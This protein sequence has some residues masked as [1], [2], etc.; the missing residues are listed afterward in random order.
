MIMNRFIYAIITVTLL[1]STV[2]AASEAIKVKFPNGSQ[3]RISNSGNLQWKYVI[4]G[5]TWIL[6]KENG[7]RI[8]FAKEKQILATGV[9]IG[10]KLKMET[11]AGALF[12]RVKTAE[13]KIKFTCGI[14]PRDYEF[15]RTPEKIKVR[16]GKTEFGKIKYY[17]DN[18]KLKVKNKANKTVAELHGYARLSAAPGAFLI[19]DVSPD[20]AVFMVLL[21]CLIGK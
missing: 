21:M 16:S 2:L 14:P 10:E 17:T 7:G 20:T 1:V 11:P 18:G 9:F 12:I 6:E 15:K 4:D 13:N 3:A 19:N 5:N 8:R